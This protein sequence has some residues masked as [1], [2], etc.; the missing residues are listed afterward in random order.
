MSEMQ[1]CPRRRHASD[2]EEA[3]LREAAPLKAD[4]A[5][6][7][8]QPFQETGIDNGPSLLAMVRIVAITVALS[9]SSPSP[10]ATVSAA[11]SSKLARLPMTPLAFFGIESSGVDDRDR[12]HNRLRRTPV[13]GADLLDV[14]GCTRSHRRS[15]ARGLRGCGVT[16]PFRGNAAVSGPASLGID[17]RRARARAENSKRRACAYIELESSL[18]PHCDYPVEADFVRC[19]SCLRKLKERCKNCSR[20]LD[21]AWTICPYCETE[22]AGRATAGAALRVPAQLALSPCA[23][24]RA[25]RRVPY[26]SAEFRK[27]PSAGERSSSGER[28]AS[29][30]VASGGAAASVPA[31][32]GPAGSG[33]QG[34]AGGPRR[35][36][37]DRRQT[38][39]RKRMPA[40]QP[41]S[42][43]PCFRAL[44]HCEHAALGLG[45]LRTRPRRY[46]TRKRR[47]LPGA[48]ADPHQTRRLRRLA[49][50]PDHLALRAQGP[51]NRG[52]Q[53]HDTRR[54]ARRTPLRRARGAGLLRRARC[55]H[56]L[57]TARR[58]GARGRARGARGAPGDRCDRPARGFARI[59][60]RRL[61]ARGRVRTSCTA[62]TRP[63]PRPARSRSS[64][65]NSER[66]CSRSPPAHR[67]DGRSSSDSAS[68]SKLWCPRWRSSRL[69][70]RS[71]S[72]PQNAMRKA[73]AVRGA[74]RRRGGARRRHGRRARRR[75]LRQASRRGA[76]PCDAAVPERRTH[77]VVGGLALLRGE[78][79]R[80]ERREHPGELPRAGRAH[81]R[82]VP[83]AGGVARARRRLRD[84]GCGSGAGARGE[85][86]LRECRRPAAREPPRD[87]SGGSPGGSALG[88]NCPANTL[89]ML[90]RGGFRYTPAA[91]VPQAADRCAATPPA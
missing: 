65:Q 44:T 43:P 88:H 12:S 72:R 55:V 54:R 52:A 71:R 73:R 61:R 53:A 75:A 41:R 68:R 36:W 9:S 59:D 7:E 14:C 67:S 6:R 30:R 8:A 16:F 78:E 35:R 24:T 3:R 91:S 49:E 40:S 15:D 34:D 87:L 37:A 21:R 57:R 69:A 42:T 58:D 47:D 27:R 60:P 13:F 81:A 76:C 2:R 10:R 32:G 70:T 77:T 62:P 38:A 90:P 26:P 46:A 89:A 1:T 19:P 50:R 18:C 4:P 56:H 79:E 11:G 66:T 64:S 39:A 83:R 29:P 51:E 48:H 74:A 63:S 23:R 28:P 85:G 22:V 17:R 45:P 82:L 20:P 5:Q 33:R 25:C 84:P 86:R 31:A 80:V